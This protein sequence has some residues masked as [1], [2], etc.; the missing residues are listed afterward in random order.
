[1]IYKVISNLKYQ[2]RTYLPNEEVNMDESIAES[3]VRDGVLRAIK[4]KPD[5]KEKAQ[6]K[7]KK[8][9]KAS[10]AKKS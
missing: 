9:K 5:E 3:L 1:M 6:I 4:V 2:G 10:K 7:P 8:A